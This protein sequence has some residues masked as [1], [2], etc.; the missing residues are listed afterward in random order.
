M[1]TLQLNKTM[2]SRITN[3][4]SQGRSAAVVKLYALVDTVTP[5]ARKRLVVF[6]CGD[7][8]HLVPQ[9][10]PMRDITVVE[11]VQR[12][13]DAIPQ[14]T[15]AFVTQKTGTL[16]PHHP[17]VDPP[18]AAVVPDYRRAGGVPE[19]DSRRQDREAGPAQGDCL[20]C[21]CVCVSVCVTVCVCPN[22]VQREFDKRL[23][24]AEENKRARND[25]ERAIAAVEGAKVVICVHIYINRKRRARSRTRR[26][27]APRNAT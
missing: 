22:S 27:V 14:V 16:L 8:P 5:L 18:D 15:F 4:N 10:A 17:T 23:E 26:R 13:V 3:N 9:H 20:L 6:G 21:V 7:A 24:I 2:W 12:A 1:A 19:A 25:V 11:M